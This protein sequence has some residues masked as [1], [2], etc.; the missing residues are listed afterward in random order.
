MCDSPETRPPV[1]ITSKQ[2]E[3][4]RLCRDFGVE[5]LELFGS[6]MTDQFDSERSDLDFLIAYRDD[7]DLGPWMRDHFRFQE[8]LESLFGRNVDLVF[9]RGVRNPVFKRNIEST[10]T[11]L[12][13][14]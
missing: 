10:R 6:A 5:R 4:E 7:I 9:L 11:L 8:A 12:Y 3:L 1:L 2:A 14:A 13:A